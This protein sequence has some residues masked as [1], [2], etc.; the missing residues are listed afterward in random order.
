MKLSN[1]KN[2]VEKNQLHNICTK[3][4]HSNR[5]FEY[6]WSGIPNKQQEMKERLTVLH[7][8]IAYKKIISFLRKT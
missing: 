4:L 8:Y 3:T 1:T 5:C 6:T 7:I 2:K